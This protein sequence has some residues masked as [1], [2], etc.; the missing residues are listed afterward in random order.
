MPKIL[1][2][3]KDERPS[4]TAVKA[5]E[6]EGH[7]LTVWTEGL[8]QPPEPA[9]M[10][11]KMAELDVRAAVFD[12]WPTDALSIKLLQILT[13]EFPGLAVIFVADP[14]LREGL[15]P[16]HVGT[17]FNEGAGGLL[18]QPLSV[19]AL[20]NC[21]KRA[22]KGPGRWRWERPP[23]DQSLLKLEHLASQLKMQVGRYEQL[24]S[25]LLATPVSA[26]Q[27]DVLIVSDS[28]YQR[29][30]FKRHFSNHNFH[31]VTAA[32][33][34]EALEAA[35]RERPR[36]VVSDYELGEKNG[37]DLCRALKFEQNLIP[38]FFVICTA[39]Q[40]RIEAIKAPGAGVD[41][42]LLKPGTTPEFNELIARL[43]FG[44]LL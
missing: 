25:F 26:Q 39:S 24:I 3:L 15:E 11:R 6:E 10:A 30:L 33:Y 17:L 9:A 19:P 31:A 28:A 1:V 20:N 34:Q 36:I 21:L 8:D 16:G 12:Y 18:F 35:D 29:D 5:L 27:R 40:N 32:S 42:C 37:V 22:L 4:Q 2:A 13:D 14:N 44:L 43:S 23:D 41:D 38:C 7:E